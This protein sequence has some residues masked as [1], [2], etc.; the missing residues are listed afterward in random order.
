LTGS[1][2]QDN[3]FG[4][5]N[6]LGIEV[7]TSKYNRAIV[8]SAVDP[9]FTDAGVSRSY[10][11]YYKTASPTS[12]QGGDYKIVTPGV[13]VRFGVPYTEFDTVFFGAGLEQTS[14]LGNAGLPVSYRLYRDR[15]GETTTTVPLTMGWS[16]DS[17]DSVI[18]PTQ[19][20][21][22]RLNLEVGAGEDTRYARGDYQFQ[23]YIPLSNRYALG[24]NTQYGYGKGL[25][26][27]SFPV[28]KNFY[29]GG[30]G[31]V[32][33]FEQNTLGPIDIEGAYIGGNRRL[34]LNAELYV[35]F[36]GA[37][38]DKS[39][40]LFGYVDAGNVW[41]E[42]EKMSAKD[43][44]ASAGVGISWVSP[45]GPLKL[46][47]GKPFRY[48]AQDKIQELQFQIGTSF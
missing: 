20:R 37:G 16:R 42:T 36:P 7:N 46:S 31:S 43:L 29:G 22:Q 17:R 25:S 40:R 34:T 48:Q 3:I 41:G 27:N 39:L 12:S 18:A 9:Y 38:N 24:F 21:Y 30:L 11:V 13:A 47:Y 32:R 4:T 15:H 5:G 2:K 19:G 45:V 28:F 1:I 33:G 23:Q 35:P 44:R 26:G 10:D 6:Y 8:L 14:I